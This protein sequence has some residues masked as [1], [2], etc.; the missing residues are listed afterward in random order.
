M[1]SVNC[2]SWPLPERETLGLCSDHV[3]FRDRVG[4]AL[5]KWQAFDRLASRAKRYG[6]ELS[7]ASGFRDYDRQLTL[8]NG[9]AEG[10]R[11]V[12]NDCGAVLNRND[13]QDDQWLHHIL[14]F[15]AL[16]GTSRHHWG[17]DLDVFDRGALGENEVLSLTPAAYSCS[18]PMAPL[19]EWLSDL[20]AQDNAEGFFRP[21]AHDTGGV[22]PEAWHLSYRP[23]AAA[24]KQR[25]PDLLQEH[26]PLLWSGALGYPELALLDTVQADIESLAQR[27]L[28]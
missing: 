1:A 20:I 14:R 21:Y 17:S 10:E 4:L 18:G 2:D 19:A 8:F 9:K 23:R 27:F 28:V 22:A 12:E 7:V 16:P 15:S 25:L 13:W 26:L 6:F 5:E 11:P 24:Y 3:C